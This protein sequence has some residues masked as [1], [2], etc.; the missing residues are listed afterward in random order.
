MVGIKN[1]VYKSQD[2]KVAWLKFYHTKV[3]LQFSEKQWQF[4]DIIYLILR[5]QKKTFYELY[6]MELDQYTLIKNNL[7]CGIIVINHLLS[8]PYTLVMKYDDSD[9][10]LF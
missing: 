7:G 10:C 5:K 4:S 3:F 6:L 1:C 2:R 9:T 8:K